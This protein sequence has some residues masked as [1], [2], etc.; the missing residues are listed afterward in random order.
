MGWLQDYN[1]AETTWIH[2]V[3]LI[4]IL[5]GIGLLLFFADPNP[6]IISER[7]EE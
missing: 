6:N 5:V 1:G 4:L 2:I 7:P 3:L